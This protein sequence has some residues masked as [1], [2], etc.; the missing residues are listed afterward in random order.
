MIQIFGNVFATRT[1]IKS[2][3]QRPPWKKK[4]KNLWIFIAVLISFSLMILVIFVPP[5][6]SIFKTRY[7]P[8]GFFFIPIGFALL[9][10]TADELRKLAVRRKVLCFHKIAW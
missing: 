3:I 8:V 5:I 2:I 10:L 1:A 7:P 4:S 9:L 6:N